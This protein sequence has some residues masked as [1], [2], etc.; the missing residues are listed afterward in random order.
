MEKQYGVIILAAGNSSRLGTPKQLVEFN[1]T[2]LLDQ[3]I[4]A[5]TEAVSGPV[6]IVTGANREQFGDITETSKV[7]IAV[8]QD[9][10]EGMASSIRKGIHTIEQS[11]KEV[12]GAII[13]VCDQP[14]CD[15]AVLKQLIDAQSTT[16]KAAIASAYSGSIG[17]PVLFQREL[18]EELKKLSGD[19]GA[20]KLLQSHPNLVSTI[21][22]EKGVIDIDTPE[23]LQKLQSP[24][25]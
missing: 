3:A 1:G 25:K 7:N 20:K 23:D 5:A 24:G 18:F 19:S 12:D 15:A 11:G 2:P 14:Y 9:W 17:T 13:M 21:P 22:F 4:K 10:E 8:N 6:I 16:G